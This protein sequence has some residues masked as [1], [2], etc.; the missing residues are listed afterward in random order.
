MFHDWRNYKKTLSGHEEVVCDLDNKETVSPETLIF[1]L[2]R[3]ISEVKKVD[4]N[5]FPGKTLYTIIICIQFHLETMGFAYKIINDNTF[6]EVR[7]TLDN[8]MKL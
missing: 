1:A 8:L 2:T 5:D 3:F 6:R 4:G 7:Y